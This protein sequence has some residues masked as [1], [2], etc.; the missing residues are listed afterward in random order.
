MVAMAMALIRKPKVMMFDEPSANLAPKL[1]AQVI[2]E[3]SRLR[4]ELG[5]TV[6]VVEQIVKLALGI[7]DRAYLLV[8]GSVKFSGTGE[9][10]LNR[11]DLGKLYLGVV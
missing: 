2:D 11:P 6:V 3:I 1:A 9:E 8:S 10:L 4:D 5:I 7:A